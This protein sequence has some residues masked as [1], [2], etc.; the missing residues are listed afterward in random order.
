[1]KNM[2]RRLSVVVCLVILAQLFI[3]GASAVDLIEFD[4][5]ICNAINR[6]SSDWMSTKSNRA[7][8]TFLLASDASD[9]IKNANLTIDWSSGAFVSQ[10]MLDLVILYRTE[11]NKEIAL[12]FRPLT[13]TGR[14]T[15]LDVEDIDASSFKVLNML[16]LD[17][18]G[19]TYYEV[20]M[21]DLASAVEVI[22]SIM[23]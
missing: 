2:K 9:E 11:N 5:E 14:F 17:N 1:M 16:A 4:A 6:T 18:Q 10:Q 3:S 7:L 12:T 22:K 15:V 23:N 13:G 21:I 8:L 19:V 20:T